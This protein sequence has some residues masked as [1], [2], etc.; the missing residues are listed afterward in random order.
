[1]ASSSMT[2]MMATKVLTDRVAVVSASTK[3]I[4]F[5]IAKRLGA[6][7]ASVVVSSR[8]PKNV[9][10][11]VS[12]LRLEGIDASGIT[13]HV[14]LKEDRKRLIDFAIS[15]YG[16]L[17]ILVSNAAAN[18]HFGDIMSISDSQWDKLL[19][20]NVRSALQLTQEAAPHL[21]ASGRGSVV[22]V[23][24][25]AGYAPIDG[26]GAYSVMKSTLIGLN[27]ALSQSLARRNIRVNAIAPGI[28]RTDFSRALYANEVDHENWLR[29]I[30]LNRLGQA[31]ECAEAV[32]FLV[33]DEASY[34]S[35]ET[36]GVNGGMQ[37][38]I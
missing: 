1:M 4:G 35:G 3:G 8:K 19:T 13:A 30:P 5:A 34:I 9:E 21:E 12:A 28:I 15:Q 32:A 2:A 17:D 7:G 36:I 26:L 20:V 6:D 24:S 38:H 18:P 10:E 23:S 37:A 33:S 29:S 22:L 11:A 16:K 27:K 25:V 31:E 14:G